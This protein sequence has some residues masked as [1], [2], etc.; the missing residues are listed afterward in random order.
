MSEK[1]EDKS[2]EVFFSEDLFNKKNVAIEEHKRIVKHLSEEIH[3][4]DEI[5]DSMKER[6]NI[7]MK[8]SMKQGERIDEL[9]QRIKSIHR[10]NPNID[11]D[12]YDE[13]LKNR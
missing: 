1:K 7:I 2:K 9:L 10:I 11:E 12:D 8:T 4:K 5:I 3:R 6:N 13:L